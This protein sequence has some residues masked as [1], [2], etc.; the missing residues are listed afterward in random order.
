MMHYRLKLA[1]NRQKFYSRTISKD[2]QVK[3]AFLVVNEDFV[4]ST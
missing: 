3:L 2:A 4:S 1:K